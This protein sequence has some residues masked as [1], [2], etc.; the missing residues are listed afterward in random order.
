M[1]QGLT[2]LLFCHKVQF[3]ESGALSLQSQTRVDGK[4]QAGQK[5]ARL[6]WRVRH[7]SLS[8]RYTPRDVSGPGGI[9]PAEGL[10]DQAAGAKLLQL[11]PT[12][13]DPTNGSPPGSS[14]P[15]ILQA[16]ILE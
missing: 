2:P 11:C 8:R 4:R 16:R 6:V 15:G 1:T 14:V 13:C 12:L 3:Q 5:P 10:R 9:L 7:P